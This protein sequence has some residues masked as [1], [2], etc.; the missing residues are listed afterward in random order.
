MIVVDTCVT[1]VA[2]NGQH[3]TEYRLRTG[4]LQLIQVVEVTSDAT[5]G[6]LY[7]Q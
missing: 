1:Q 6:S 5:V 2:V 3:F 7:I 4:G